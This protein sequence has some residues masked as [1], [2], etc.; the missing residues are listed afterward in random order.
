M[1]ETYITCERSTLLPSWVS[2]FGG[3]AR[4]SAPKA[5]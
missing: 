5:D 2:G 3:S 4:S 1:L